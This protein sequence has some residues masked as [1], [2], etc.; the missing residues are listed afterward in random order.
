MHVIR[1][2]EASIESAGDTAKCSRPRA[3]INATAEL[4]G[5]DSATFGRRQDKSAC[6]EPLPVISALSTGCP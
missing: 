1:A 3:D 6:A 4:P 2:S 5:I